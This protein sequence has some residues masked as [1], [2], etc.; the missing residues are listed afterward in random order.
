[1][2]LGM[3]M[4]AVSLAN[5]DVSFV[6]LLI[7]AVLSGAGGGAFASSMSNCAF[8]WPQ[9]K[10]GLALGINAGLGNLGV[11]VMQLL[12]P[13]AMAGALTGGDPVPANAIPLCNLKPASVTEFAV[14]SSHIFA[15]AILDTYTVG[16]DGE[17]AL[18]GVGFDASA[19]ET[20]CKQ[21]CGY[22]MLADGEPSNTTCTS[23]L[24][25]KTK[26]PKMKDGAV[27][28]PYS[29]MQPQYLKNG[30]WMWVPFLAIFLTL[31][32]LWMNNMPQHDVGNVA[33]AW[34][35]YAFLQ[36]QGYICSI[37]AVVVLIVSYTWFDNAVVKIV[38]IFVMVLIASCLMLT[39]LKNAPKLVPAIQKKI[40]NQF[41]IFKSKHTWCAEPLCFSPLFFFDKDFLTGR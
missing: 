39:C 30:G 37:V 7:A 12:M 40:D 8:F 18:V 9:N 6:T 16:I 31:S 35:R 28:S 10:Q 4:V 25:P 13:M 2:L 3:L 41:L 23:I 21:H 19:F 17:P 33:T 34:G 36:G 29:E 32:C 14:N 5:P 15:S 26:M 38:R 20:I 11:S 1:M 22:D 27:Q 24:N